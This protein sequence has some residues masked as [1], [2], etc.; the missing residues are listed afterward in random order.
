VNIRSATEADLTILA[1]LDARG[2]G[3]QWSYGTLLNL[4]EQPGVA[5]LVVESTRLHGFAVVRHVLDEAEIFTIMV[6]PGQR[7]QGIGRQLLI[8]CHTRWQQDGVRTAHLE[9][10]A[11]NHAALALYTTNNWARTG[12]RSRYYRDGE[13]ALTLRWDAPKT[14]TA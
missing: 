12:L 10:R 13:D 2:G 7:R 3:T 14:P 1:D 9:V 6:E 5:V 11:S 8:A 4:F